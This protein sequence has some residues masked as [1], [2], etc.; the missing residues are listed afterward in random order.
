MRSLGGVPKAIWVEE[1]KGR[2]H[3]DEVWSS[4]VIETSSEGPGVQGVVLAD[5]F[6]GRIPLLNK[7]GQTEE[8]PQFGLVLYTRR[9]TIVLVLTMRET[10]GTRTI[11]SDD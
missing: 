5:E 4:S 3:T 1:F 11:G 6:W 10:R 9:K 8:R 2:A 7:G